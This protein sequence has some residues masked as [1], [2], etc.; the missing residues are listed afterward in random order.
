MML[1]THDRFTGKW[2]AITNYDL[3]VGGKTLKAGTDISAYILLEN[4]DNKDLHVY[5]ESSIVGKC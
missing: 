3:K 4:K 1:T 5:N 2:H